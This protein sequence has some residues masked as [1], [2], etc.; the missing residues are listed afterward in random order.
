MSLVSHKIDISN[1]QSVKNF[2]SALDKKQPSHHNTAREATHSTPGEAIAEKL[3]RKADVAEIL[4]VQ[5]RQKAEGLETV[6][7]V[8]IL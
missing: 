3:N 5:V 1:K 4:C 7:Q 6:P 8:A 2:Q